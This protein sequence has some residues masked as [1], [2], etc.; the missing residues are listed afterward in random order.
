[1]VVD[2]I[3]ILTGYGAS[4]VQRIQQNLASTNTNASGKTSKSLRFEVKQQGEKTTLKIYGRPFIATVET[5]RKATPGLKPSRQFVENIREWVKYRG[6][7]Q[8][9]AYAIALSIN[10]KG[11]PPTGKL[12]ISNVINQSLTD[13]I[14]KDIL[15]KFASLFMTNV[16]SQYV[17]RSN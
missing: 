13:Q 14:T 17:G 10:Q 1:M 7:P 6:I 2:L 9:A 12:I 4:T 5:G 3:S 16:V 15:T 8:S 11:T